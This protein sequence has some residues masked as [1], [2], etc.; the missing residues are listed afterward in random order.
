MITVASQNDRIILG[1]LERGDDV[2]QG[3]R[4][5]CAERQVRC[6]TVTA[7]GALER[8]VV[9]HYDPTE[10][11]YHPGRE[12]AGPLEVLSLHGNFSENEGDLAVHVHVV[13][14]REGD[15]GVEVLGGHLVEGQ[16]FAL[17]FSVVAMD[18]VLL[19]RGADAP[20]GL[21]LWQQ[22]FEA[23]AEASEASESA[24]AASSAGSAGEEGADRDGV[25]THVRSGASPSARAGAGEAARGSSGTPGRVRSQESG[26]ERAVSAPASGVW[27]EVARVSEASQVS[28][29]AGRSG[30][31][32]PER[33]GPAWAPPG[34][35]P[36]PIDEDEDDFEDDAQLSPGDII[37]HPRFGRCIAERIEGDD[38][39]VHVR[40]RN[41]NVVRLS[42]D[43]VTLELLGAEDGHQVFRARIER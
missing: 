11:A 8:A 40:L 42:L 18:D 36:A 25:S 43:V 3:L 19:R 35:A 31:T 4:A 33:T 27:S 34:A 24:T 28:A 13:L 29:D 6:G 12:L 22:G 14:S 32:P 1:R 9:T 41:R 17:E 20:T 30:I 23:G 38:E 7:I 5:V 10:R 37:E 15:N 26:G 2:L 39:Y 16:V 21:R